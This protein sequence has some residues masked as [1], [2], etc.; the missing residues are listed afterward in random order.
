MA[1]TPINLNYLK[2]SKVYQVHPDFINHLLTKT[3]LEYQPNLIKKLD[4]LLYKEDLALLSVETLF[5]ILVNVPFDVITQKSLLDIEKVLGSWHLNRK[6]T[7]EQALAVNNLSLR[8]QVIVGLIYHDSDSRDLETYSDKFFWS[9]YKY[10]AHLSFFN[11]Y[12]QSFQKG[13][14]TREGMFLTRNEIKQILFGKHL[15][16]SLQNLLRGIYLND[17]TFNG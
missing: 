17:F 4:S 3:S 12:C 9:K 13:F 16:E 1:L 7:Y 11:L 5:K 2:H 6:L 14:F 15:D 8:N 10:L